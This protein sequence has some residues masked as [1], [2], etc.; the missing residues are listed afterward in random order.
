[1]KK[2]NYKGCFNWHGEVTCFYC[3]A[4]SERQAV[5]Y[6]FRKL[7]KLHD[8]TIWTVRN[9]FDGSRD[10]YRITIEQEYKEEN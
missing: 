2:V 8:V 5:S 1:M 6:F 9:H 4:Y 10:N 3:H 7:A